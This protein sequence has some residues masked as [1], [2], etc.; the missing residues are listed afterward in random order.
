MDLRARGP[1]MTRY[2]GFAAQLVDD[3]P[4]PAP[5]ALRIIARRREVKGP[6]WRLWELVRGLWR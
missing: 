5:L 1:F 2:D 4:P 3:A 6:L